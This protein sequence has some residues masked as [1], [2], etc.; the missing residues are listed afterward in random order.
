MADAESSNKRKSPSPQPG[1]QHKRAKVDTEQQPA[2]EDTSPLAF[3]SSARLS[4]RGG[5]NKSQRVK[6]DRRQNKDD[7]YHR[8]SRK[9]EE[10][11][12]VE[13]GEEREKRL[14]KRK[15]AVLIGYCGTG[16]SGSQM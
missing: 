7:A 3:R 8:K 2:A 6:N 9:G 12:E 1:L 16:L 13:D 14:P 10:P 5:H 4:H 15:V 11:V